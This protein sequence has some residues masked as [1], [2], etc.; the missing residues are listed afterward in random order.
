MTG[1][2]ET[3]D[4]YEGGSELIRPLLSGVVESQWDARPVPGR[5]SIR[6]LV[7]HLADAEI[8]YVERIKRVLVEDNPHFVAADPEAYRAALASP[9]RSVADELAVIASLRRHLMPILRGLS[10]ADLLR[11]CHHSRHGSLTL[12]SLLERAAEHIPHHA[13]FLHEKIALLGRDD[14]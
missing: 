3:L 11:P 13:R 7:C 10:E 6:E 14:S 2:T 4:R 9:K 12:L 8:V 5:W 1:I